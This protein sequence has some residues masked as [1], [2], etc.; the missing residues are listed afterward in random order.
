MRR[1]LHPAHRSSTWY[2]HQQAGKLSVRRI[3]AHSGSG[4]YYHLRNSPAGSPPRARS[5][6]R[7]H[8][9]HDS[10]TPARKST[11]RIESTTYPGTTDEEFLGPIKN[12]GFKLVRISSSSS[13]LNVK[14]RK[15]RLPWN[16][17]PQGRGRPQPGVP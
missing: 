8:P 6:L 1:R 7:R 13:V 16:R 10:S 9:G 15:S 3:Y 17:H 11:C 5:Q 4:C 2:E 14:I 12:R